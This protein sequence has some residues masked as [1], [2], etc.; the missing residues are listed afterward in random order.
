M[1]DFTKTLKK[2]RNDPVLFVRTVIGAEPQR[3]QVKALN[4]VAKNNKVAIKSGHGVGKSTYLS[5]LCLWF[6]LTRLP[7]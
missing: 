7:S 5:W 3:W 1:D 6:L 2:L 4:A